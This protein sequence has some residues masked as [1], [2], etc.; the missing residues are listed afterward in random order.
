[1]K[2]VCVSN[3]EPGGP[4]LIPPVLFS[5]STVPQNVKRGTGRVTK[6][7]V[8][9]IP[10]PQFC[11]ET[12]TAQFIEQT[13]RIDLGTF[14]PFLAY[15]AALCRMD[16][17][18]P[19]HPALT[20]QIFNNPVPNKTAQV[21]PD[22]SSTNLVLLGDPIPMDRIGSPEWW[23]T[24]MSD[25]MRKKL[26]YRIL[27]EG[28]SLP[29]LLSICVAVMA[30]IYT[31]AYDPEKSECAHNQSIRLQCERNAIIDFGIC[32]GRAE[33]KSLDTFG[34]LYAHPN[35]NRIDFFRG[36][37]PNDHYW[38]YFKTLREEFML[39]LSMFTFNLAMSAKGT[40]YTPSSGEYPETALLPGH[41]VSREM[42][43]A[44]PLLQY[45]KQRFS[46]LHHKA[47]QGTVRTPDFSPLDEKILVAFMERVAGRKTTEIERNLLVWW[48]TANRR[49]TAM[50]LY[51][52]DY[53]TYP[54]F[55]P[56]CIFYDPGEEDPPAEDDE[57]TLKYYKRMSRKERSGK[58][59]PN[60]LIAT[61]RKWDALPL[62][63]KMAKAYK[64]P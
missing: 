61:M 57:I 23:P 39:E 50:N 58:I 18:L 49:L 22:G 21:L 24:A 10:A 56:I 38:I 30:E 11:Y 59:T 4:A 52:K 8:V 9:C 6:K 62:E 64:K 45:E 17:R 12:I 55:V 31:T 43:H 7:H 47:L 40:Y 28:W 32:K 16:S 54:P 27:G 60:E 14:W 2:Y 15:M 29:L 34:Y 35:T 1:M 63:E 42:R 46:V 20:H 44:T 26:F 36:Q 41:F 37:D 19:P 48:T 25:T 53:Y 5:V 51:H 13:E 3:L 33:V